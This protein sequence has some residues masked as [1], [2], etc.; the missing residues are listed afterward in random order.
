MKRTA[1]SFIIFVALA[2]C[3]PTEPDSEKSSDLV[4]QSPQQ[5]LAKADTDQEFAENLAALTEQAQRYETE[6][7][8]ENAA[9]EWKAIDTALSEKYGRESWQAANARLSA[10]I[11]DMQLGFTGEQRHD[12]LRVQEL[13]RQ[14]RDA[15]QQGDSQS[16]IKFADSSIEITE[17]LFGGN[18]PLV[19][20]QLLQLGVL[21]GQTDQAEQAVRTLNRANEILKKTF[22]AKHPDIERVHLELGRIYL[23]KG[24]FGPAISNLKMATSLAA[25]LWGDDS[26]NFAQE[27]NELAVAYQLAGQPQ[28]SLKIHQAAELIR[29]RKLGPDHALVAHSRL[30]AAIACID[31]KDYELAQKY[32]LQ[33][34]DGFQSQNQIEAHL[35]DR[36]RGKLATVYMLNGQPELAEPLLQEMLQSQV[37]QFGT[38]HAEIAELQYRLGIAFAKQGK[39][40]SAEPILRQALATQHRH[41]KPGNPK[42]MLSMKAMA[43]LLQR[44]HREN[45]SRQFLEE[46]ERIARKSDSNDFLR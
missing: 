10:I 19:G 7:E 13:Q 42:M 15:T 40:D 2:G 31:L 1:F 43:L 44:T 3:N 12:S 17:S 22:H 27:A 38:D 39:Y 8:F 18:S 34:I 35:L 14:F 21:Y 24:S 46:I 5:Q 30:N 9:S 41:L 36:A 25:E 32:L 11:C 26:L 29:M 16:A 28:T 33:A 20:K 4:R 23:D 37:S 6:L 45:E